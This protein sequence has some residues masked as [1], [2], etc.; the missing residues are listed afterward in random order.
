MF[1]TR[2]AFL[3]LLLASPA[4]AV[5]SST[6]TDPTPQGQITVTPVPNQTTVSGSPV[7]LGG[8]VT[9][10]AVQCIGTPC[11]PEFQTMTLDL[12]AGSG[13]R[14]AYVDSAGTLHAAA[15]DCGSGSPTGDNLGNHIMLQ[16][17]H[18]A[19]WW[20]SYGGGNAGL[21]LDTL[22]NT[23]GVFW[24]NG[25]FAYNVKAYPFNAVGDGDCTKHSNTGD[26]A[27]IQAAIDA[28]G[29]G[30]LQGVRVEIP[31]GVYCITSTLLVDSK[32][33]TI[34]GAGTGR[35]N[36]GS[37]GNGAVLYWNG[38]AAPMMKLRRTIGAVIQG[39]QFVVKNGATPPTSAIE[40]RA[41]TGDALTNTKMTFRDLRIGQSTS[42]AD[43]LGSLVNGI[44][45][46]GDN[47]Q[48]D[49]SLIDNVLIE[50]V[51][52]DGI[53]L[54]STQNVL[55]DI[56]GAVINGATRG[57][58]LGAPYHVITN[59]FGQGN[60]TDFYLMQGGSKITVLD[61]TSEQSGRLIQTDTANDY[62]I[63]FHGGQFQISSAA[64]A[65]GKIV[66]LRSTDGVVNV[67]FSKFFF[68][69]AGGG[70]PT[71]RL[72]VASPY[73]QVLWDASQ[74]PTSQGEGAG[75]AF[76]NGLLTTTA[77]QKRRLVVQS[78]RPGLPSFINEWTHG[79]AATIDATRTDVAEVTKMRLTSGSLGIGIVPAYPL[80][81]N[82]SSVRFGDTGGLDLRLNVPNLAGVATTF[83]RD[84]DSVALMQLWGDGGLTLG[85]PTGGNQ[86]SGWMNVASG[87]KVNNVVVPTWAGST[88][89]VAWGSSTSALQGAAE[90]MWD[91]TAKLLTV[92]GTGAF[93]TAVSTPTIGTTTTTKL[94]IGTS[95][96]S[97]PTTT[98]YNHVFLGA[99]TLLGRTGVGSE[100]IWAWNVVYNAGDK[101]LIADV[102][103]EIVQ[104]TRQWLFRSAACVGCI[105]GDAITWTTDA[106]LTGGGGLQLSTPTGGELGAGKLN[107][108]GV[109]VNGVAVPT[110]GGSA[111]QVAF[112]VSGTALTGDAG[113]TW[114]TTAKQLTV[115][116][117]NT[118]PSYVNSRPVYVASTT[119][120]TR[121]AT[122]DPPTSYNDVLQAISYPG[123]F[124]LNI[125]ASTAAS[126]TL[127]YKQD[128]AGAVVTIEGAGYTGA[129]TALAGVYY[130]NGVATGGGT[131]ERVALSGSIFAQNANQ[132][133]AYGVNGFAGRT[134][135]NR[136]LVA[137]LFE[138]NNATA[139]ST[140]VFGAYIQNIDNAFYTTQV[141]QA[142]LK[143]K[144]TTT[145]TGTTA[146]WV[147]AVEVGP[148]NSGVVEAAPIFRV[149]NT[150]S[151]RVTP[152]AIANGDAF[153]GLVATLING[154]YTVPDQIGTDTIAVSG[155]SFRGGAGTNNV[156]GG[157]FGV[158]VTSG[159]GESNALE[160]DVNNLYA[161]LGAADFR[162][163]RGVW[164]NGA[165]TF[166]R[167]VALHVDTQ[168]AARW[169]YGLYFS[170]STLK[171]RSAGGG[172]IYFDR[173]LA[174]GFLYMQPSDDVA[175]NAIE[176]KNAAG[177]VN[178][179]LV[180]KT[181]QITSATGAGTGTVPA[182]FTATGV[183]VRGP[184]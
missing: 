22:G 147:N 70:L 91:N 142:G 2:L 148:A 33:P 176:L 85:V 59:Y 178:K 23:S 171:P 177:S 168:S 169:W 87:Y 36:P 20:I 80:D 155:W 109:Y 46:A 68:S 139:T 127:G 77:G 146:A 13:N 132:H 173:A 124:V 52:G 78:Q 133:N 118:A 1:V 162:G 41:V 164:I 130:V 28:T 112:G 99:G 61:S 96:V 54:Y 44:I 72:S 10:G 88:G 89:Q 11:S 65:D 39:L 19:G 143:I 161:D 4:W 64:N 24:D 93:T 57:I 43:T 45:T 79:D 138:T 105:A 102:S 62:H 90:F 51:T 111:G 81:V 100:S 116:T 48:N 114:D 183:L 170:A 8:T 40:L 166:N 131:Q 15:T 67:T 21:L 31:A 128:V 110:W 25:G 144:T 98:L 37:L 151:T 30:A 75:Y 160:V 123:L 3:L 82:G 35:V 92:T 179:F 32:S 60:G 134:A 136:S 58:V 12:L 141:G 115:L 76:F 26:T 121:T 74:M 107:A 163:G 145:G 5:I 53:G 159:P 29:T 125:D 149:V 154:T 95:I 14:C 49:Q 34:I 150:G 66:D 106:L 129:G 83:K 119:T 16:N 17:L 122:I 157:N 101:R 181:G 18:T 97:V 108:L 156:Y 55:W 117:G 69:E 6:N 165:G 38:G 73:A 120:G 63:E 135:V 7:G 84:S 153:G 140:G 9:I 174:D 172:G 180:E 184:C 126:S 104:S 27:A 71:S 47:L 175:G 42:G 103:S 50:A 86:H 94:Q 113:L 167:A 158:E 56:R 152:V 137:G 182:C